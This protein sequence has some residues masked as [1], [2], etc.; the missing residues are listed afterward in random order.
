[1]FY[2]NVNI[3]LTICFLL[4]EPVAVAAIAVASKSFCF[5]IV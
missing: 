5:R 4:R 1:M 2:L 3:E